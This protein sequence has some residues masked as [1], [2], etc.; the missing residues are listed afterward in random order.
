[1]RGGTFPKLKSGVFWDTLAWSFHAH[2][3][4]T[5]EWIKYRTL[6]YPP[7]SDLRPKKA[8]VGRR[9][10]EFWGKPTRGWHRS[11]KHWIWLL[12]E[13]GRCL[14]T[15]LQ[16]R[17]PENFRSRRWG[18]ERRVSR[19]QTRERGPPSAWAEIFLRFYQNYYIEIWYNLN[20]QSCPLKIPRVGNFI[21]FWTTLDE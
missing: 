9:K 5:T 4:I 17:V 19:A 20:L 13:W 3:T 21:H 10:A 12:R 1:M 7:P 16:T 2:S 11:L 14:K 18:A 15:T 8:E 6:N